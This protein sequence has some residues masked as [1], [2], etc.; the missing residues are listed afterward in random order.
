[1]S[2]YHDLFHYSLMTRNQLKRTR[3]DKIFCGQIS[4]HSSPKKVKTA[5]RRHLRNSIGAL[6]SFSLA[7]VEAHFCQDSEKFRVQRLLT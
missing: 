2:P 6:A 5:A 3:R 7:I 4:P 1:M